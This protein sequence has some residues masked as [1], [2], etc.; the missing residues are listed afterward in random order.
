MYERKQLVDFFFTAWL[1]SVLSNT[2]HNNYHLSLLNIVYRGCYG[3][4][5]LGGQYGRSQADGR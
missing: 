4:G 1:N 3:N 5:L 2:L